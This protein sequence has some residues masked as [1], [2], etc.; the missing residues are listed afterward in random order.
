MVKL[1][2]LSQR[3]YPGVSEMI[4]QEQGIMYQESYE[5][6]MKDELTS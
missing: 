6:P 4:I 5:H 2:Q 1:L 3:D